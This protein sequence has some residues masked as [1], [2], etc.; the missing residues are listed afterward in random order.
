ML[1]TLNTNS[2]QVT[3]GS[4]VNLGSASITDPANRMALK[5]GNTIQVN[6]LGK[7]KISGTFIAYNTDSSPAN[8]TVALYA[9][10]EQIGLPMTVTV[11]ETTGYAEIAVSKVVNI[12]PSFGTVATLQFIPGTTVTFTGCLVDD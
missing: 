9:N 3:S 2:Q 5:N 10:G 1:E 11:P 7:Y 6:A 4:A 8:V 12:V